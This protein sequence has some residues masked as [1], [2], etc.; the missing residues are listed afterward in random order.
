[1]NISSSPIITTSTYRGYP[2]NASPSTPCFQIPLDR[3]IDRFGSVEAIS[4]SIM[5][6]MVTLTF[7]QQINYEAGNGYMVRLTN[8]LGWFLG[9]RKWPY[10]YFWVPEQS[11]DGG[12]HFH[13]WLVVGTNWPQAFHIIIGKIKDYWAN[14]LNIDNANGIVD[15]DP[16]EN[17]L[18]KIAPDYELAKN[19]SI[20]HASYL[21]KTRTKDHLSPQRKGFGSSR[22][23][24]GS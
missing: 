11:Q 6:I 16:K 12:F 20:Y 3:I 15:Y 5:P 19:A 24:A 9:S 17:I 23:T 1:M 4:P 13:L 8:S 18:H 14:I 21:A 22:L 7:P 10:A 2:I